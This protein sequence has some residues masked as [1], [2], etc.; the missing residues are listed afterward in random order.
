MFHVYSWGGQTPEEGRRTYRLKHCGNNNIDADNSPKT[1][2]DKNH[3]SLSQKFRQLNMAL[4]EIEK[5]LKNE[6][7]GLI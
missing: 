5:R 2:Y 4:K 3:Q 6:F 1:L 7:V